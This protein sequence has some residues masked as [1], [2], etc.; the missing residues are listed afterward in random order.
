M[1][2]A[3]ESSELEADETISPIKVALIGVGIAG[4]HFK[5]RT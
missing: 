5:A 1:R 3:P 4:C 2:I